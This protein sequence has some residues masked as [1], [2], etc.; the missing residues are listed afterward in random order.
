MNDWKAQLREAAAVLREHQKNKKSPKSKFDELQNFKGRKGFNDTGI[1]LTPKTI[2]Q[3]RKNKASY[4]SSNYEFSKLRLI[5][6]QRAADAK[7]RRLANPNTKRQVDTIFKIADERINEEDKKLEYQR[8]LDSYRYNPTFRSNSIHIT[9][10]PYN[11][12]Y[13]AGFNSK[14][15]AAEFTDY[16]LDAAGSSIINQEPEFKNKVE[17]DIW[18]LKNKK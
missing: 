17:E 13:R 16:D 11:E 14:D 4:R 9:G 5:N 18:R 15:V 1:A 3:Q 8:R 2:K 7:A 12:I 10:K 6:D